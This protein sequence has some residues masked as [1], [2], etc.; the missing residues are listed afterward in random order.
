MQGWPGTRIWCDDP[1]IKNKTK[2]KK[3]RQPERDFKALNRGAVDLGAVT[4]Q[5][6]HSYR[7]VYDARLKGYGA[8]DDS[9]RRAPLVFPPDMTF[10]H[11]PRYD[12][13]RLEALQCVCWLSKVVGT[14]GRGFGLSGG[15]IMDQVCMEHTRH[16]LS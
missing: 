6:V 3:K 10:G 13:R 7:N 4:N 16:G 9:L 12:Y 11:P 1:A 8:E 2:K 5:E 14:V 15:Q